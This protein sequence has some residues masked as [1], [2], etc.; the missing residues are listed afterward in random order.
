MSTGCITSPLNNSFLNNIGEIYANVLLLQP[1]YELIDNTEMN[2][3]KYKDANSAVISKLNELMLSQN[4]NQTE[5]ARRSSVPQPTVHR[6]LSGQSDDPKITTLR[7]MAETLG[8]SLGALE[9]ESNKRHGGD[10]TVPLIEWN[11]LT[12]PK[13][14]KLAPLVPCPAKHGPNTFAARVK[15]NTMTA[16]YGRSY[17]EGSIIYIDPDQTNAAQPGDRVYALIEGRTPSFKQYGI[18]DDNQEFLQSINLQYPII[19]KA[20]EIKGLVIGM[21]MPES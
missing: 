17:P 14:A 6:I 10:L 7:K 2:N 15:D 5:M 18:A 4:M 20:F 11:Q 3:D 8:T 21:W 16:Q 9:G 19:T 12:T 13:A 1:V